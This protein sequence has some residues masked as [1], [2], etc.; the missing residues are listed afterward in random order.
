MKVSL[1]AAIS[2]DG[3]IARGNHELADWSSKED[4]KVFV[5]LTKRAGV[6]VMGGNTYRTI[7]RA[8]PG[9]RNIVYSRQAISQEGIE[10]TQE[11]PAA[12][13]ERLAREGHGEVAICGGRAIYNMFLQAGLITDIYLTVE[14]TLF[15]AGITLAAG[16]LR[17]RLRLAEHTLLNDDT[18]LLHYEVKA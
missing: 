10:T 5:R 7:G 17:A 15:G 18:L 16:S 6:M 12:L 3:F 13:L 11:A 8:L 14:P 9:R 2:A 1:I 4:K